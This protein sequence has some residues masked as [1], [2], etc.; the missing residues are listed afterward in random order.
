MSLEQALL[1]YFIFPSFIEFSFYDS[2]QF[3][4]KKADISSSLML[5]FFSR[6]SKYTERNFAIFPN[7]FLL[8]KI[9]FMRR[10]KLIQKIFCNARPSGW[11]Y[12]LAFCWVWG[13]VESDETWIVKGKSLSACFSSSIQKFTWKFDLKKFCYEILSLS[14]NILNYDWKLL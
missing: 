13:I 4:S 1:I 2:P 7:W 5:W 3:H 6:R 14:Q 11:Q 12:F 10:G 9:Q 8:K